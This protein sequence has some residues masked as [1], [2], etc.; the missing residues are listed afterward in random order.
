MRMVGV[1]PDGDN[2]CTESVIF[3]QCSLWERV[4][5][6]LFL[7]DTGITAGRWG[8]GGT[9]LSPFVLTV[10]RLLFDPFV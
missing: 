10:P 2:V 6:M 1:D 8:T 5:I 3:S 7:F 4:T 9:A